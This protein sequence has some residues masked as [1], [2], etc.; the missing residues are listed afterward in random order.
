MFS[1]SFSFYLSLSNHIPAT[2]AL[3]FGFLAF[4]QLFQNRLLRSSLLLTLCFY[5]HIGVSWLFALSLLFYG[6]FNKEYRKSCFVVFISTFILALPILLKQLAGI[7][8]ISSLGF[9][10]KEKYICKIKIIEYALAFFGLILAFKADKKYRLF[11][12]LFLTSFIFLV[13]PYRFFSAEGYLPIILLSALF[14]YELYERRKRKKPY[15]KYLPILVMVFVLF[16]SPTLAMDWSRGKEKLSYKLNIADSAFMGMVLVRASTIW[17]PREYLSA[18]TLVKENS[19][20]GDIICSSLNIVGL[21]LGSISQR[22]TANA[23]FPEIGA[24]EKFDPIAVSKIIIFT[25]ADDPRRLSQIVNNYK[26]IK[27]GENKIFILYKNPWCDTKVN[28]KKAVVSFWVIGLIGIVFML[29]LWL[30]K[31]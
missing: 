3:I 16:L 26:L 19:E 12:S 23:L 17:F 8:F 24:S 29:L 20:E 6:L 18:A 25:Q 21:I 30:A 4:G 9:N 5:T 27:I 31:Y 7:R 28:I 13:Y 14:L 22:P 1:S 11:A 10:L 15:F 2:L